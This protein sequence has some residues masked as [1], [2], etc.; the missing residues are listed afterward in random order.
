MLMVRA[1]LSTYSV[2]M[3][4]KIISDTDIVQLQRV[5]TF[6]VDWAHEWQLSISV[7][8][9]CVLNIGLQANH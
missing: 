6:L 4:M 9:C 7:D 2:K 5:V 1:I 3:Y 8:K